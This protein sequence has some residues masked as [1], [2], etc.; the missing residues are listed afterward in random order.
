MQFPPCTKRNRHGGDGM[1][2]RPYSPFA[3]QNEEGI[4]GQENLR[5]A[6]AELHSVK[7]YC[8][9]MSGDSSQVAW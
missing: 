7:D 4:Q 5:T 6:P 3:Q 2:Y 9:I 1:Q 8:F